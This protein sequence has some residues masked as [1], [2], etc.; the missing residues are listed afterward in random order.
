MSHFYAARTPNGHLVLEAASALQKSIRRGLL[1]DA[2][3]WAVD[4]YLAGYHEY[5]WKRMRIICSEDVGPA[6]ATLPAQIQALYQMFTDQR[7][8]GDKKHGPERLFFV[9][10]VILLA[11]SPKCRIV[12]DALVTHFENHAALKR[13][14]P[15]YALDRHN[16]AGRALG[17]GVEFL[18]E[19]SFR[20]ENEA[21]DN[22]YR[23]AARQT[24]LRLE[25]AKRTGRPAGPSRPRKSGPPDLFSGSAEN[26]N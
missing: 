26:D 24:L 14:V 2:L 4:L 19:E 18:F 17:R 15:D 20:L 6:N 10:A 23:E 21:G 11:R 1:D 13:P 9:H 22:P 3:Y 16:Q 5:A 25:R 8:K 12:D 7:K